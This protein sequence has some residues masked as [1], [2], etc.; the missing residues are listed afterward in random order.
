M[1]GL[2]KSIEKSVTVG[3]LLA[4]K[5]FF[6][7]KASNSQVERHFTLLLSRVEAKVST[8]ILAL[9]LRLPK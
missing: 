7:S 3:W 8:S 9:I 5:V 1:T 6:N 2:S 4:Q